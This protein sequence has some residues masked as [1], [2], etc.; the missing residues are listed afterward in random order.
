M[1]VHP[2]HGK[3]VLVAEDAQL[4]LA[5]G[6]APAPRRPAERAAG[7]GMGAAAFP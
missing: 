1:E 4:H 5:P 7:G 6:T 3:S 2:P